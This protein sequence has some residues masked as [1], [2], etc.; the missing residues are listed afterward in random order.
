MIFVWMGKT[1]I[2]NM[3]NGD[4]RIAEKLTIDEWIKLRDILNPKENYKWDDAFDFFERRINT[5][6]I[7]PI[8]VIRC[9]GTWNGEGFAMVNL[10]C[11]LIETIESFYNGWIYE[12]DKSKRPHDRYY[13]RRVQ[14]E[15]FQEGVF[16]A[17]IFNSFFEKRLILSQENF[18]DFQ[19]SFYSNV[20][21]GLLHETQTKNG[22]KI[23]ARHPRT[24]T[25][26]EKNKNGKILYRNNF[27]SAIKKVIQNYKR[28][29]VYGEPY[30]AIPVCELRENFIA[31][32]DRICE[33]SNPK[34]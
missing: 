16:G 10:Q 32:F 21:C 27:H 13:L 4:T 24:E 26:Y 7:R 23:K 12:Y 29:I 34:S 30:G 6:Y 5:R 19:W 17:I 3:E 14:E 2:Y 20:R 15:S 33:L 28:A 22:W 8:K 1:N 18:K 11:S 31:K 9:F 25:F